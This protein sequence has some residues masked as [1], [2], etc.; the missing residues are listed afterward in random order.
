MPPGGDPSSTGAAA[1]VQ[2]AATQRV[3][4]LNARAHFAIAEMF[5][6]VIDTSVITSDV[7][8]T[9][10]GGLPSPLYLA[11]E[12]GWYGGIWRITPGP[13]CRALAK[14]APKE[15]RD[16]AAAEKLWWDHYV[17]LIRFVSTAGLPPGD[18]DLEKALGTR[19]ASKP[20]HRQARQS[21]R[22]RRRP[23]SRSGSGGH[24]PCV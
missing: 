3:Q 15:N 2:R 11:M 8:K 20:A 13:R 5:A 17:K 21:H 6:V 12:T 18:P 9:V 10:K 14:R 7:I 19:D 24:W 23:R 1:G 16:L 22:P 4:R